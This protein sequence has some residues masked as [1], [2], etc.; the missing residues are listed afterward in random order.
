VLQEDT[1]EIISRPTEDFDVIELLQSM[2]VPDPITPCAM[3]KNNSI[4]D[5][6]SNT[7]LE[8]FGNILWSR[9]CQIV[10]ED[11]L[12]NLEEIQVSST[13]WTVDTRQFC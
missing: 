10:V 13:P 8:V 7:Q 2:K 5:L 6:I 4:D 12:L 9:A 11:S 1:N 3:A